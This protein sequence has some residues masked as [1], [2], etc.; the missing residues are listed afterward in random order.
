MKRTKTVTKV[1][2]NWPC[3]KHSIKKGGYLQLHFISS[4]HS[5]RIPLLESSM[6][7]KNM[8]VKIYQKLPHLNFPIWEITTPSGGHGSFK[9]FGMEGTGAYL[10]MENMEYH[11]S[12]AKRHHNL[13]LKFLCLK[14]FDDLDSW[15]ISEVDGIK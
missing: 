10:N 8:I 13:V 14:D 2:D 5:D 11:Q 3:Q 15:T 7:R 6:R 4:L 9:I 12:V 1:M